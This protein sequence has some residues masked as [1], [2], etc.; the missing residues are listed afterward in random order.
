MHDGQSRSMAPILHFL[1]CATSSM[2]YEVLRSLLLSTPSFLDS[3][4]D[5]NL[6][7]IMVPLFPPTSERQ[8]KELSQQHWPTAYKGGNPFGPHPT[9]VARAA[10]E[11]EGQ[12]EQYMDLAEDVGRA[13]AA[14]SVGENIGAV[15]VDR[16]GGIDAAV[17]VAAGDARWQG[18]GHGSQQAGANAMAHPVMRVIGMIARKRRAL[19]TNK[20]TDSQSMDTLDF[21]A[22][23]PITPLEQGIYEGSIIK[24]GGYLCLDLELYVTHEPCVMCCMAINHSRLARVVFGQR[25]LTGGL[26]SEKRVTDVSSIQCRG[27]GLWWRQ[28]LNWRFLTWQWIGDDDQETAADAYHIHA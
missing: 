13:T 12:V 8:A 18:T 22:D 25:M 16:S 17:L 5:P 11:I 28:E 19:L 1:I 23:E 21:S 26:E 3:E 9:I 4:L 20:N 6:R 27:Y 15:V 10:R 24:A 14:S 7:V 2:S